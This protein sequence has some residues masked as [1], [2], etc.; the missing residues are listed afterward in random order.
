TNKSM[1]LYRKVPDLRP[2]MESLNEIYHTEANLAADGSALESCIMKLKT[3]DKTAPCHVELGGRWRSG[4]PEPEARFASACG[5]PHRYSGA[6]MAA[7]GLLLGI[8]QRLPLFR[9]RPVWPRG[10]SGL[11][12]LQV[13]LRLYWPPRGRD[14][15]S[16]C[17]PHP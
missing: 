2:C 1:I 3:Y 6:T 7:E 4:R 9:R 10:G 8:Y 15:T 13:I 5:R 14:P 11:V 12:S 16:I 17:S